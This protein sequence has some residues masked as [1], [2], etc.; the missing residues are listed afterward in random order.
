MAHWISQSFAVEAATVKEVGLRDAD[1]GEIFS[2]ARRQSAIVMTKDRDF[3]VLLERHGP[4]P[5]IIWI[6]CGNTSNTYLKKIL[7]LTLPSALFL[8][9]QGERLIEIGQQI[10]TP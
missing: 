7:T 10:V 2:A 8:I 6:T 9:Q 1:D 3:V 4:P 5:S